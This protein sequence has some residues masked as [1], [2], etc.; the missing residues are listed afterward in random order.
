M[1]SLMMN[2]QLYSEC[3]ASHRNE[4]VVPETVRNERQRVVG[5]ATDL[6]SEMTTNEEEGEEGTGR[7]VPLNGPPMNPQVQVSPD[8]IMTRTA[9]NPPSLPP[10]PLSSSSSSHSSDT[11]STERDS[12]SGT[13]RKPTR[14][15]R[16]TRTFRNTNPQILSRDQVAN[17]NRTQPGGLAVVPLMNRTPGANAPTLPPTNN[18]PSGGNGLMQV[19]KDGRVIQGGRRRS[20]LLNDSTPFPASPSMPTWGDE[21]VEEH[22]LHSTPQC[23][24]IVHLGCHP[25]YGLLTD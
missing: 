4:P 3:I 9:H 21:R 5:G 1:M 20:S 14:G 2:Q 6:P 23:R 8:P 10:P 11:E 25:S 18:P 22:D 17:P 24:P 7:N 15:G 13:N 12:P 16:T 19:D